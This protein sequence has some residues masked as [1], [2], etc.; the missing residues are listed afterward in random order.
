[1]QESQDPAIPFGRPGVTTGEIR[2]WLS[3]LSRDQAREMARNAPDWLSSTSDAEVSVLVVS[4]FGEFWPLSKLNALFPYLFADPPALRLAVLETLARLAPEALLDYL[5][6]LL[7]APDPRQRTLAIKGLAAIDPVEALAHIDY[8]MSSADPTYKQ[9]GVQACFFLPFDRVKPLALK[10]VATETDLA[11]LEPLAL[12]LTSNPDPEV[13]LRLWEIAGQSQPAKAARLKDLLHEVC[14]GLKGS[15]LL[16]DRFD[17]YLER[18]KSWGRQKEITRFVQVSLQRL[19]SKDPAT[20]AET[21][22]IINRQM[23]RPNVRAAFQ[24]AVDWPLPPELKA[25]LERILHL[26]SQQPPPPE[27]IGERMEET[28]PAEKTQ[29]PSDVAIP[30][31]AGVSVPKSPPNLEFFLALTPEQRI[32]Y[33][34]AWEPADAPIVLPL[35]E[36]FLEKAKPTPP[37][38]ATILRVACLLEYRGLREK[39]A[40]LLKS[41]DPGLATAALD[42]LSD[43]DPDV[44]ILHLGQFLQT[45]NVRM[46]AAAI[47]VMNRFDPRQTVS[48]LRAMLA[49][50]ELEQQR[51]AL[52]CFVHLDFAIVKPVLVDFLRRVPDAGLIQ[53][54]LCLF[55]SN[56]DPES[57]YDLF[58]LGKQLPGGLGAEARSIRRKVETALI[59]DGRL[60]S[61]R[62]ALDQKFEARWKE[63]CRKEAEPA[64]AYSVRSLKADGK[65]PAS[66]ADT[67]ISAVA[68]AE[69][70]GTAKWLYRH[71]LHFL[72]ILVLMTSWFTYKWLRTLFQTDRQVVVIG[73]PLRIEGV[74]TA[75]KGPTEF[76]V[77]SNRFGLFEIRLSPDQ[78]LKPDPGDW[79]QGTV[80]P[81]G[82][83]LER[84]TAQL[85]HLDN[86][87]STGQPG[88]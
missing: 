12:L 59:A 88:K 7:V 3:G 58:V 68:I 74:V 65:L 41:Q 63:E 70:A 32:E 75:V 6:P 38:W 15:G 40:Q 78:K 66:P 44:A 73:T 84:T 54:C 52:A 69:I 4:R 50:K 67:D 28:P 86:A 71:A 61:D 26:T 22:A 80:T 11:A 33:M 87:D 9:A 81:I 43:H 24:A 34:A 2:K 48:H 16:G 1:M 51:L 20:I 37:E 60:S 10:F 39:A 17:E 21:E 85:E 23:C 57:L 79:F 5:P 29:G 64:P 14:R 36:T 31:Q 45:P 62:E 19:G 27:A 42:Y 13:P 55:A 8:L 76:E 35:L 18:L 83:N 77:R 72:L 53:T 47:R 56:P 30:E 25:C 82:K 46:K 49:S